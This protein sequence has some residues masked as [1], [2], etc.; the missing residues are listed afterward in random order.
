MIDIENELITEFHNYL[1]TIQ[2]DFIRTSKL[3][4]TTV[5]VDKTYTS[6]VIFFQEID[7][8]SYTKT[9]TENTQEN[10][11]QI[12]YEVNVYNNSTRGTTGAKDTTRWLMNLVDEY[13]LSKGFMRI[14]ASFI[15]NVSTNIHRMVARYQAVVSKDKTI[16]RR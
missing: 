11:A 5:F 15:P 3:K 9:A 14:M 2:D 6:P 8:S 13:M 12:T 16:Y 4:I 10:H 7:N 1:N